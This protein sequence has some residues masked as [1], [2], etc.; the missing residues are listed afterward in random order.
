MKTIASFFPNLLVTLA[1][2]ALITAGVLAS[3][4]SPDAAALLSILFAAGVAGW[5]F[6]QYRNAPGPIEAARPVRL[7]IRRACP[8]SA[9]CPAV[10]LSA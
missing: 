4:Q 5:T 2:A 10:S 9:A 3:G 8:V 6:A 1:T 7:P